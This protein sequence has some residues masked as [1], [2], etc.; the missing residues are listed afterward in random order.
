MKTQ[1]TI[2]VAVL[3]I[4]A[5]TT[6]CRNSL[7]DDLP[8]EQMVN[9]K[10]DQNQKISDTLIMSIPPSGPQQTTQTTI[11]PSDTVRTGSFRVNNVINNY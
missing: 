6:S 2:L 10:E 8:Q 11:P 7:Y 3:G 9:Y 5:I 4:T 1:K